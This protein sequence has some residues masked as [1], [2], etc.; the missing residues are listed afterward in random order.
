MKKVLI[1]LLISIVACGPSEAEIQAQIDNAVEEA[2]ENSSTVLET[3][4]TSTTTTVLE[5]T[6]TTVNKVSICKINVSATVSIKNDLYNKVWEDYRVFLETISDATKAGDSEV[7]WNVDVELAYLDLASSLENVLDRRKKLPTPQ[8]NTLY[9]DYYVHLNGATESMLVITERFL[10]VKA[11]YS[12]DL[13]ADDISD[14]M[15]YFMEWILKFDSLPSC[16]ASNS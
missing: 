1:I 2:L 11:G 8:N 6:T 10:R 4:T 13:Y 5:T 15:D 16:T 9:Q 3:T 12:I 7:T 14:N